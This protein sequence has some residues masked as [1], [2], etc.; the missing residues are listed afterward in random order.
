MEIDLEILDMLRLAVKTKTER[1]STRVG[2]EY[3]H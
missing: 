1:W 2:F 3:E